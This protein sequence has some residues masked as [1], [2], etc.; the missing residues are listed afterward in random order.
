MYTSVMF[1]ALSAGAVPSTMIPAAPTWRSDYSLAVKEGQRVKRPL[2]I[3]VSPGAEGWDKVI[4]DGRLDKE[5]K[6]LLRGHYVCVYLDS[7]KQHDR[8]LADQLELSNGRGVVLSDSTGEKQAFWHAGTL[9][10]EQLHHYLR[11][12]AD[13]QQVVT[14]TEIVAEARP[15]AAPTYY[16][17]PPTYYRAPAFSS[18]GGGCST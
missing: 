16:A 17:P 18:F 7:T 3:F 11:K 9:T 1:L 8:Q 10:T 14:R 13:P 2:A 12:Y 4:G 15:Q 6:E 5:A